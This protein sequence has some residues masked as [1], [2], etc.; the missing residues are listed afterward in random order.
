M[1]RTAQIIVTAEKTAAPTT[2]ASPRYRIAHSF[3]NPDPADLIARTAQLVNHLGRVQGLTGDMSLLAREAMAVFSY[4]GDTE[5]LIGMADHEDVSHIFA[6]DVDGCELA[7]LVEITSHW[8]RFGFLTSLDTDEE[9]T[10]VC[11]VHE[12]WLRTGISAS[13]MATVAEAYRTLM[14]AECEDHALVDEDSIAEV[15][16][17]TPEST[18]LVTYTPGPAW[19]PACTR[20]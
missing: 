10:D 7:V 9:I 3:P 13:R 5:H 4:R 12:F 17:P 14:A 16:T 8:F 15:L 6:G 20:S 18:L 2:G 11:R 1:A 19:G